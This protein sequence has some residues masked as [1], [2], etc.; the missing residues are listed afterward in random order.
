MPW[1]LE[2]LACFLSAVKSGTQLAMAHS[3]Q[4]DMSRTCDDRDRGLHRFAAWQRP[5]MPCQ[6]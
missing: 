4:P 2:T 3:E 1:S 6:Q 5:S